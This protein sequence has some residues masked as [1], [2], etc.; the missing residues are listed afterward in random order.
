[1]VF[2]SKLIN[3]RMLQHIFGTNTLLG[4]DF[5]HPAYQVLCFDTYCLPDFTT[6]VVFSRLYVLNN[7]IIVFAREWCFP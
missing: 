4:I 3:P 6:K 5:K 1:M 7:L 2:F